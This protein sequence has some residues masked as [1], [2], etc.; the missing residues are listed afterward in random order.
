MKKAILFLLVA[1]CLVMTS[2]A[3]SDVMPTP[4]DNSIAVSPP[5]LKDEPTDNIEVVSFLGVGDNIVYFGTVRDAK[6]QAVSGGRT[7]NFKP[8]YSNVADYIKNADIAFINQETLMCGEGY[9]FTYYPTFNGPQDMGYDLVELGFDVVGMANNHMLDKSSAGLEKTIQ[10]WDT[11][12]VTTI[13]GYKNK[14]DYNTVRIHESKGVK[15]A[16]LAYCQDTN[17]IYP[18]KNHD[19][20]IPYLNE[21]DIEN[22]V[23]LAKEKSDLVFVSVHW[24]DEGAFKPNEYQKRFAKKFAEAGVDVVLG[25]H[26]HVIQ[27][28]EW[29]E[30]KDGNKMLCVYSLGNFMAEQEMAYNM[31]GGMISFDIFKN[32][33]QKPVIKNV[34]FIP[35]VFDWGTAFY[36]NKIHLLEEYTEEM[37]RNHGIKS[38]GRSTS[39]KQLRGYVSSTISD[40]FLSDSYKK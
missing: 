32:G 34:V 36:N 40:E 24:G 30:G 13:G 29:I 5:V 10:F 8:I 26:P 6:S 37:A 11:L 14:A 18:S 9:N 20:H 19:A 17:G 16:F 2:C 4:N 39:L 22:E 35:T 23:R 31:V 28:V 7:Y 33:D 25:H 38:Y 1:I 21:A 12:P 27:P 15:I 3:Q